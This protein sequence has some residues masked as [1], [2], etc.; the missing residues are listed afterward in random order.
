MI[1]LS[2]LS[3]ANQNFNSQVMLFLVNKQTNDV[4]DK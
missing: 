1:G 4:R 2:K 3:L